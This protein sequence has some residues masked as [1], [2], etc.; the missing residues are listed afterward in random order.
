MGTLVL[1]G[2]TSGSTTLSPV[3]AV[4]ATITL[5]SATGAL[6]TQLASTYTATLTGCTTAPTSTIKYSL[7]GNVV[8]L[9]I[10]DQ[11]AISNAGTKSLT[12]MPAAL[13]PATQNRFVIGGFDNNGAVVPCYAYVETTGVIN[14]YYNME[15]AW[16]ASGN[17]DVRPMTLTYTLA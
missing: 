12:G 10:P 5:P 7:T 11:N 15:S 16:T 2:A 4:T 6:V 9:R 1:N 8:T 17:F 3:D 13:W 14:F